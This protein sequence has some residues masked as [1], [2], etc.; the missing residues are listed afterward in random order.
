MSLASKSAIFLH[1]LPA[2]RG[3]EVTDDVIDGPA[4]SLAPSREPPAYR[5]RVALRRP[6]RGLRRSAARRSRVVA[7]CCGGPG[8]RPRATP[9]KR[10]RWPWLGSAFRRSGGDPDVP[11]GEDQRAD[12]AQDER[13]HRKQRLADAWNDLDPLGK[14]SVRKLVL[15]PDSPCLLSSLRGSQGP[16]EPRPAARGSR[17]IEM[18]LKPRGGGRHTCRPSCTA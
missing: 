1:C 6:Y 7:L 16:D 9:D 18:T 15:T 2:H 4:S 3:E 13:C 11:S 5:D 17:P 10:E 14:P 12:D 8:A